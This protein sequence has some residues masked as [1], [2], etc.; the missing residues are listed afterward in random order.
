MRETIVE[1][2]MKRV[3]RDR[4][5]KQRRRGMWKKVVIRRECEMAWGK[6]LW[7]ERWRGCWGIHVLGREEE[8]CRKSGDRK[9]E[10]DGMREISWRKRLR[11]D[12]GI[13]VSGRKKTRG[14]S[15]D[16]KRERER[17]R[18]RRVEKWRDHREEKKGVVRYEALTSPDEATKKITW[19]TS[20]GCFLW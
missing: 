19:G 10:R 3:L 15:D 4:H 9:R 8:I 11:G 14:K 1:R 12:W 20:E 17:E 13:H 7:R 2:K 16:R 18:E 6:R 5:V